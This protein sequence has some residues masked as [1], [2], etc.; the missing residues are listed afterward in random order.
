MAYNADQYRDHLK[1]LLPPGRAFPRERGSTL[2]V[3]LDAMALELARI[4]ARADQLTTEAV[5]ATTTELLPD[6][7]ST[8][9]LPDNCSGQLPETQQGRRN[10]LVSKLVAQ[11]GQSPAYFV[12][13]AAALGFEVTIEEFRPFRAG[14]SNPGDELTNGDWSYAWRVRAPEVTV[15]PF[16]A[17]ISAAGER[18]AVW[19]NAGLECRIRKYKPAH[20]IVLFA[21]GSAG[22][23]P[24]LLPPDGAEV[25]LAPSGLPFLIAPG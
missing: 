15:L 2:D 5:P 9:G 10:D 4:D 25:L 20:T 11:G 24:L 6:W 22:G 1:A 13:L 17:G 3:L 18:L 21:Y 14:F 8:A 7:E 23:D 19:G 12:A 16:R